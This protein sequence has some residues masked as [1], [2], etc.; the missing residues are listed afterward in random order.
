MSDKGLSLSA[1]PREKS[2]APLQAQ[3]IRMPVAVKFS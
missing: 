3:Q 1:A 2:A